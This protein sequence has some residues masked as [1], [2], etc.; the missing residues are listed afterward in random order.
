MTAEFACL[1]AYLVA[2]VGVWYQR[3]CEGNS[4]CAE[5][6]PLKGFLVELGWVLRRGVWCGVDGL[7]RVILAQTIALLGVM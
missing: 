2:V 6:S 4:A 1:V 5:P 7:M 3:P